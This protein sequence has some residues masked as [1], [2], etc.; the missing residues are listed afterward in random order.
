MSK[1]RFFVVLS[2]VLFIA[3]IFTGFT[4][5]KCVNANKGLADK[6]PYITTNQDITY[7]DLTGVDESR[8]TLEDLKKQEKALVFVFSRPCSPCN[9]N[10]V[11]WN[12]MGQILGDEV[13]IYGIVL[14]DLTEAYNFSKKARLFFNIFIPD[15]L[16]MFVKAWKIRANQPMTILV[17]DG[18]PALVVVGLLEAEDTGEFISRARESTN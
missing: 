5:W 13:K 18:K 14:D 3:L 12:K 15:D 7:F 2:I 4:L 9:K 10:L 6:I 1:L 16:D 17:R 11:F 8:V